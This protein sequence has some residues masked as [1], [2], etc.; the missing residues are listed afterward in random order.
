MEITYLGQSSFKIKTKNSIVITDPFDSKMVG[1]KFEKQEANIVTISHHHTDHDNLAAVGGV[2][3]VIDGPG[4][5]DI[6]DVSIRGFKTFH[7]ASEGK[8]RGKNTIYVIEEGGVK[9]LHLGDLGHKL[10]ESLI[11]ELGSIDVM[12]IPVGG[13]YTLNGKE[14]V[15]VVRQIEPTITVPMH[16][17]VEAMNPELAKDMESADPFLS[18]LGGRVERMQKLSLKA[19]DLINEEAH[20]VVLEKK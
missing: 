13:V 15:E 10:S 5:Y 16:F 12:M 18:E 17:K 3:K 4:E 8:E 20:V 19:A 1:L 11:K 7:D 6:A 2:V 14:A 9:V